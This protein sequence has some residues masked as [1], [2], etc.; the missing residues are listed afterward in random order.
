MRETKDVAWLE[1]MVPQFIGKD[2]ESGEGPRGPIKTF[3]INRS[4]ETFS[5]EIVLHWQ[6]VYRGE[7]W[8]IFPGLNNTIRFTNPKIE[9][10]SDRKAVVISQPGGF[11]YVAIQFGFTNIAPEG[12]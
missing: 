3:L 9:L 10:V 7:G 8:V 5:V 1:A 6:A 11:S 2:V 12:L 4:G